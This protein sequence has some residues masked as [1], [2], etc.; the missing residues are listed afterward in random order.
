MGRSGE[1]VYHG[2]PN[3]DSHTSFIGALDAMDVVSYNNSPNFQDWDEWFAVLSSG[4][5]CPPSAG[6]DCLMCARTSL[7]SEQEIRLPRNFEPGDI[8]QYRTALGLALLAMKEPSESLDLFGGIV[9]DHR[10]LLLVAE[11]HVL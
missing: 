5:P 6:T 7:P 9:E 1:T 2:F 4:L 11:L 10:R 8:Y 3:E